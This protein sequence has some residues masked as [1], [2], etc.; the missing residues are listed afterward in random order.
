[1]NPWNPVRWLYLHALCVDHVRSETLIHLR[2]EERL[3]EILEV[4][5]CQGAIYVWFMLGVRRVHSVCIPYLRGKSGENGIEFL[6]ELTAGA[7]KPF[8]T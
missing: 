3:V 2:L 1:M 8:K 7:E 4:S 5:A 6:L